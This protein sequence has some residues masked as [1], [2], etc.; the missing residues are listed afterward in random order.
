M[1][2][3]TFIY[4]VLFFAATTSFIACG[5]G[6]VKDDSKNVDIKELTK[7]QPE[8]HGKLLTEADISVKT[9]LD[10]TMVTSG[11]AI[12]ELKCQSCHRLNDQ[13]IVGPGWQDV[14]KR[15]TPVWIMN[16]IT[17]VDIM[18]ETD[19]EAQKQLELCLVRMPNQNV[20]LEEARNVLEFM[21]HNDGEK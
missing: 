2:L 13:R 20:S 16:M 12:Y 11:K 15:R 7:G 6:G 3:K 21:R 18:L 10:Q 5:G 1:K 8:I 17:N 14:T 19:E 9:P 4:G